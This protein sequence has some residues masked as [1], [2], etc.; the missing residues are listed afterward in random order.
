MIR[1]RVNLIRVVVFGVIKVGVCVGRW[2]R[3]FGLSEWEGFEF[4]ET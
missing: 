3:G 2:G 1:L 4:V